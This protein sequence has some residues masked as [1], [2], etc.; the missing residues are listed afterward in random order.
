MTPPALPR[1]LISTEEAAAALDDPRVRPVDVRWKLGAPDHGR[2]AYAAGHLPGAIFLDLDTEL[3]DPEG[4]GRPGRHPLP[5]PAAFAR[6]LGDA[7][8]SDDAFVIA[9]DDSGGTT[10]ARLWWML[11]DL[12]HDAVAVLDGGIDA[13][14]AAGFPLTTEPAASP[15]TEIHLG[16]R[17]SRV[18]ERDDLRARLGE[19]GLIDARAGE[20][21]R[22]EVEPVDPVAGH[23]PTARSAPTTA[24]IGPDGRHL[25]AR[26]LAARYPE[27][28]VA[29]REVVVYCG[30]GVNACHSALAMRIAGLPDPIV[31]AGSYSDWTRSGLSVAT[32]PEPGEA[33]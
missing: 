9:Y 19:V 29:D 25:H 8:V 13:W 4:L 22:G 28:S 17:W 7:G 26:E 10:A 18:I 5:D 2:I 12:G 6:L 27:G 16:D 11:D 1:P 20:R 24:N 30:S 31:Y 21:Y 33:G 32:G 3:S 15:A 23:I 14:R